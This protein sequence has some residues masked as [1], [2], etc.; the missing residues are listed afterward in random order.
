MLI[1]ICSWWL[2]SAA[3]LAPAVARAQTDTSGIRKE[4]ARAASHYENSLRNTAPH[5]MMRAGF[6]DETVGRFCVQ[7]DVGRLPPLPP[8]PEALK[9]ARAGAIEAF[10]KAVNAWPEDSTVAAPLIRYLVEDGR[11]EEALAVARTFGEKT[12]DG[13]WADLLLA[14][15]HHAAREDEQADARFARGL[16]R[17]LPSERQQMHDVSSL[18]TREERAKYQALPARERALYHER[19]W[20]LAD[21]L[22][23]TPGNES[24]AEHLSRKVYARIL[25]HVPA[26][27]DGLGW[28]PDQEE[29]TVRFGV[30]TTRT[31]N[32]G[33]GTG[34]QLTAHY[35][36]DQVTYVPPGLLTRAHQLRFEPGAAWPYDTVR[37]HSGYAPRTLRRMEV[38]EHQVA[39]FPQS[40][41]TVLRA[42]FVVMLDD[43]AR[44]PATIEVGLFL[45]DSMYQVIAHVRDTMAAESDRMVGTLSLRLPAGATAYSLETLDTATRLASRA[46]YLLPPL[47]RARPILSDVV[48]FGASDAAAPTS[49][50]NAEFQPLPSLVVARSA[51][52]GLYLEARGLA[53]SQ[54]Q[55]RYRVDLEVLEQERPG[56]FTRLVRRLGQ[57]LGMQQDEVAPKITWT[58]EQRGTDPVSI[59]LKLGRVQLDP[60]LKLFRVTITDLSNNAASTVERLVRVAPEG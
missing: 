38:L 2:A 28:G 35:D 29:L 24:L 25:A 54:Q 12:P 21:P 55:V 1:R 31:Q 51:S 7:Y 48:I 15:A 58:Q 17:A 11:A 59:G 4:L 49:R 19:L 53:R 9:Q 36:P 52:I 16:S 50:A 42:D 34:K 44:R 13:G 40:D 10:G 6:C 14:F 20:N 27:A 8:E 22:F 5:R 41:S 46:R 60:G 26:D 33:Q 23:L 43:S 3:L 39:R 30:P 32:F 45:L 56:S 37:A 18:L 57:A 47:P